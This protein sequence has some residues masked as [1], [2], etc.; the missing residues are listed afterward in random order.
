MAR[1]TYL[2]ASNPFT[3]AA[4]CLCI[5]TFNTYVANIA[6]WRCRADKCRQ[7]ARRR[8]VTF[9]EI[10]RVR[11]RIIRKRILI[12]YIILCLISKEGIK[13]ARCNIVRVSTIV[14]TATASE[15]AAGYCL[16][17]A[18]TPAKETDKF[19]LKGHKKKSKKLHGMSII[20]EINVESIC[21]HET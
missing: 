11:F 17:P 4:P 2:A 15:T 8:A 1:G 19:R 5:N 14:D 9:T 12:W 7:A 16:F 6:A 3:F 13:S 18:G 21:Q 20:E 10:Q